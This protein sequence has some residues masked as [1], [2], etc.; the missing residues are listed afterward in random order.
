MHQLP[1]ILKQRLF[2]QVCDCAQVHATC[3]SLCTKE[4]EISASRESSLE[5]Y[6]H[7]PDTG[8]VPLFQADPS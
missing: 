1:P 8:H 2:L 5:E 4:V 6:I 7:V 3:E